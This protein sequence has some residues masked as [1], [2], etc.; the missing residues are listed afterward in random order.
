M[1]TQSES[2][3]WRQLASS[4]ALEQDYA[5]AWLSLLSSRI[6]EALCAVLITVNRADAK[7]AKLHPMATV[8]QDRVMHAKT[9]QTARLAL[10]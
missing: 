3:F 6:D 9:L 10:E 1:S 4:E 7:N 5:Q 8:P 2:Q